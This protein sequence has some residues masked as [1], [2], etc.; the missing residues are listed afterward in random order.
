[1]CGVG[2][3]GGGR[4]GLR[5]WFLDSRR[6][7]GLFLRFAHCGLLRANVGLFF[8]LLWIFGSERVE[9]SWAGMHL[10]FGGTRLL[11]PATNCA[12]GHIHTL[13]LICRNGRLGLRLLDPGDTPGYWK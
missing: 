3:G 5:S 1:M 12:E 6:V 13:G 8:W 2:G 7:G 9:W 10:R 4:K 11:G